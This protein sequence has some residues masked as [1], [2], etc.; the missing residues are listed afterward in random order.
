MPQL[1]TADRDEQVE[2]I[3]SAGAHLDGV[4]SELPQQLLA[5]IA[6]KLADLLFFL[7]CEKVARHTDIKV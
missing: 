1:P 4:I 6:G 5:L 7:F 2:A 3:Q